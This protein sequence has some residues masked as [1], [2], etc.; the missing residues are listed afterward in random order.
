MSTALPWFAAPPPVAAPAGRRVPC[1]QRGPLRA[2]RTARPPH[3]RPRRGAPWRRAPG[4]P[5]WGRTA[6]PTSTPPARAWSAQSSE[7]V[8]GGAH[9][10]QSMAQRLVLLA[11]RLRQRLG[12]GAAQR[13]LES[14][15]LT[16]GKSLRGEPNTCELF[17]ALIVAA[18]GRDTRGGAARPLPARSAAKA[19]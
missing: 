6:A 15:R 14:H 9:A 10:G 19:E 13:K 5:R 18:S 11:Q 4:R 1:G 8:G 3:T 2:W 16:S 7:A 12:A 17:C